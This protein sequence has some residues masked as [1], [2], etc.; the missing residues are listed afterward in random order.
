M[1]EMIFLTVF[2]TIPFVSK[3]TAVISVVT[4][5][6]FIDTISIVTFKLVVLRVADVSWWVI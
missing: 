1:D 3:I 2:G 4:N 6:T 5:G